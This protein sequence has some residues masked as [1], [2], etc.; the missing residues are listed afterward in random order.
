[1]TPNIGMLDR[2]LR[3]VVGLVLIGYAIPFGFAHTGWNW[4]GWIGIVP[5]LTVLIGFC[6]AYALFGLSTCPLSRK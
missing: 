5:I 6:P 4:V 2:A 3:I 1:M